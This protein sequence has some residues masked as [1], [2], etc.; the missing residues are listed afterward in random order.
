MTDTLYT[1]LGGYDG[2]AMF[3][4]KLVGQA[5]EDEN[6]GRFWAN[7][8][9]DRIARELQ[10]LIDYLVRETGGRCTI[11]VATWPLLT[12]AWESPNRTGH[13]SSKS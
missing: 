11:P 10:I 2:I 12:R 4:T 9:E 6:L 13:V 5:Q 7:R 3:A 8:G 1:R